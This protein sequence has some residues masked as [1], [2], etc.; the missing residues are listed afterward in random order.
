MATLGKIFR[1]ILGLPKP[2]IFGKRTDFSPTNSNFFRHEQQGNAE[3]HIKAMAD[4]GL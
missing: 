3:F 4:Y 2:L 1:L